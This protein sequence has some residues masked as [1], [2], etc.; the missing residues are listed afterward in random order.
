M[1]Y[2]KLSGDFQSVRR[3]ILSTIA[4]VWVLLAISTFALIVIGMAI[5]AIGVPR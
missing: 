3:I 1:Q 2:Q 5:D 4:A